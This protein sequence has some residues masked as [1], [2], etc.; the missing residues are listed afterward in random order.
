MKHGKAVPETSVSGLTNDFPAP[1]FPRLE[2]I[3]NDHLWF[4]DKDGFRFYPRFE[5]PKAYSAP[6][7]PYTVAVVRSGCEVRT[8]YSLRKGNYPENQLGASCSTA[9]PELVRALT[10]H[11]DPD[12]KEPRALERALFIAAAACGRCMNVLAHMCGLDWGY[13]IDSDEAKR[14]KTSCDLCRVEFKPQAP[15]PAPTAAPRSPKSRHGKSS[16]A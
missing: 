15:A 13:R 5:D 2:R 7:E 4:E 12:W 3:R 10:D 1:I 9:N 14:C 11:L 8:E 16:P 6:L